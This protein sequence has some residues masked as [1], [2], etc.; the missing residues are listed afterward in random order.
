MI[1]MVLALFVFAVL[2]C[3]WIVVD[4]FAD[5]GATSERQAA[6]PA[7]EPAEPGGLQPETEAEVARAVQEALPAQPVMREITRVFAEPTIRVDDSTLSETTAGVL[8]GLGFETRSP[9]ELAPEDPMAQ[10]TV[11]ALSDIRAVTGIAPAEAEPSPL[12][13]LIIQAL[14]EGQTDDAID[15]AVNAA[16]QAGDVAVPDVLVTSDGRVDTSVLLANIVAEARVA[17][18]EARIVE[19]VATI[20]GDGVE[21][22]VVQRADDTEQYRFYTVNAGDSLGAISIKFYGDARY[23]DV[24]FEANR[25]ILSSPDRIRSGQR[26]VIPE[27]G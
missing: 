7:A 23:Y 14:N 18:G 11:G 16:A 3:A 12:Q 1:R 4:P 19:P 24:I 2:L 9:V 5:D 20:G 21:V 15:A 8:A 22:R 10:M 27:L 13:A 6:L 26:L 25:A 17:A